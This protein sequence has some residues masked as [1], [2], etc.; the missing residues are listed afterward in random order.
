[1]IEIEKIAYFY[2]VLSEKG[3]NKT[4]AEQNVQRLN[5]NPSNCNDIGILGYTLNG[6]YLVKSSERVGQLGVFFCKFKLPPGANRCKDR[7][8]GKKRI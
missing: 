8:K 6:Y 3:E 4:A 1:M 5:S 2:L 7:Q